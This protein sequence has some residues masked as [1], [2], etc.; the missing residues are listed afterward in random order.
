MLLVFLFPDFVLSLVTSD[1][2]V[3]ESSLSSVRV[4]ALGMLVI[5][6]GEMWFAAVTGTGDTGAAFLIEVILAATT[7]GSS[8][9]AA[10]VMGWELAYVWMSLPLVWLIVLTLSYAWMRAEYW[11]R[12][13]I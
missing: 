4:V 7:L 3:I 12:L 13:E 1:Q 11:K 9:I 10:V 5:I 6:P 2:A 8:Y